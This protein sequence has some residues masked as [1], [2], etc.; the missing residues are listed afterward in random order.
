MACLLLGRWL[1]LDSNG[2]R[3]LISGDPAL[4]ALLELRYVPDS[5]TFRRH[6][7]RTPEKV[8]EDL[9]D[10]AARMIGDERLANPE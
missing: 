1:D 9:T 2:L 10:R 7:S 4:I 6:R 3:D 8:L 5:S